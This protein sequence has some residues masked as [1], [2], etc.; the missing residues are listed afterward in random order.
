MEK[1]ELKHLAAYLPYKLQVKLNNNVVWKPNGGEKPILKGASAT[2]TT[3]LLDDINE[4]VYDSLAKFNPIL[5]PLSDFLKETEID[6]IKFTPKDEF[7]KV[8]NWNYGTW[9]GMSSYKIMKYCPYSDLELLLKWHFDVFGL[10]EKG[11]AISI[12]DVTQAVP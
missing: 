7:D 10:I 6:G 1:L 4:G 9:Y 12:N 5:R 3:A 11:L 8:C 2:L